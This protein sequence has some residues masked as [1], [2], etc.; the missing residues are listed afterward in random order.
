MKKS[1]QLVNA[2][3]YINDADLQKHM[4]EYQ[5]K[6]E[7]CHRLLI[8]AH[9]Q[10]NFYANQAWDRLYS[11][12]IGPY[13]LRNFSNVGLLSVASPA[14]HVGDWL[15]TPDDQ[16]S[17]TSHVTLSNDWIINAVRIFGYNALPSN[18]KNSNTDLD[19]KHHSFIDSY[20]NGNNS[21]EMIHAMMAN[22]AG[23]LETLPF[24]RVLVS[25][26]SLK[27]VAYLAAD[28][29]LEVEFMNGGNIYRYYNVPEQVYNQL[30][31]AESL[32]SYFYKNIRTGYDYKKVYSG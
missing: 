5:S 24:N 1:A 2:D 8:V 13:Q 10:G 32:G 26:S 22:I 19:W 27:S 20:L 18:Q 11:N 4:S 6:I 9:S 17:I 31:S 16:N 12:N 7:S 14:N 3:A 28:N 25:S 29:I 21:G 30:M 15:L 23:N